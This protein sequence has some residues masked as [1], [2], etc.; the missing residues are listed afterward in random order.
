MYTLKR[1][2]GIWDEFEKQEIMWMFEKKQVVKTTF[3]TH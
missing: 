3:E 1:I 2:K